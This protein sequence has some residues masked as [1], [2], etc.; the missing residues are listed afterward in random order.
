M[1][2]IPTDSFQFKIVL[3]DNRKTIELNSRT[4]Y[5]HFLNTKTTVGD[6]GSMTLKMK[7]PT[8][9]E[10]QLNYYAVIIGS[11]ADYT[12]NTWEDTHAG[13]MILNWGKK[14]I[15]LGNKIIEVRKSVSDNAKIKKDEMSE[16][17][18]FA[19]KEAKVLKVKVPTKQ[20]LGYISN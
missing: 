14:K 9:S 3:K 10:N 12:G 8:R 1:K 20:E 16:C 15:K 2:K 4:F 11:I 18:E 6:I 5:Q 19:L 17:I 13:L 7:K